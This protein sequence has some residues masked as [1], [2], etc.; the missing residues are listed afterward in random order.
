LFSYKNLIVGL[1]FVLI[2]INIIWVF[3]STHKGPFFAIIFYSFILYLCGR[4]NDFFSVVIIGIFGF[5]IHVLEFVLQGIGN[6]QTYELWF[7]FLN[8]I[9]PIPLI[10]FGFKHIRQ[11]RYKKHEN[12]NKQQQV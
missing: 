1:L 5:G 9:L 7:F 11:V 4:R 12:G 3:L 6:L 10:Y 2:I 8:L